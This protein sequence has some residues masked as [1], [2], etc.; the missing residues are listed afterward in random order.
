MSVFP[1]PGSARGRNWRRKRTA[2]H[3]GV[4]AEGVESLPVMPVIAFVGAHKLELASELTHRRVPLVE[5]QPEL[6]EDSHRH[7]LHHKA[8]VVQD[9]R[10]KDGQDGFGSVAKKT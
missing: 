3:V 2:A 4:L 7:S 10:G 1:V 9:E 5:V 8:E 6:P